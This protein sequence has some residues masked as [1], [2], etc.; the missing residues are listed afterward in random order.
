MKEHDDGSYEIFS[1][2]NFVAVISAIS[3]LWASYYVFANIDLI[4]MIGIGFYGWLN[5]QS[6]FLAGAIGV[7]ILG[8][9]TF[10]IRGVPQKI[11]QFAIK[12]FT[13]ELTLNNV[14]DVYDHFLRWYHSTG[15][16][17]R[18][19]T[20]VAKNKNYKWVDVA[21]GEFHD[22]DISAGYGV[23][24]FIY[25]GKVFQLTR[26][27]KDA[28][29]TKDIKESMT[30][31][32]VGRSQDQFHALLAAITPSNAYEESTK[33]HKW[34]GD[35]WNKRGSQA[36]RKFDSVILPKATKNNIVDH[37]GTF[38][39]EREWYMKHG[40]PY[41]T[42]MILHGIPGTGK[43][44]LVRALCDKFE[45]PLYILSLNGITDTTLE[46][47]FDELPHDSLVLIEDIDTYTVT[48]D[49]GTDGGTGGSSVLEMLTLG[50]LLNAID[51]VIASDGRILIATTNHIEKLDD[52]L[53]R[54][55][56]FDLSVEIGHLTHECVMEFFSSFYPD[57]VVP[58]DSEFRGDIVPAELQALILGNMENPDAVLDYCK[59]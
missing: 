44:S 20:L 24:Y 25:G 27:E 38:L 28:A 57:F 2:Y 41:R 21:D 47:A 14:D 39:G 8:V 12:Q 58:A 10:L 18:A 59:A 54:K 17:A 56:R 53:V 31:T 29:Q 30:I 15:R 22:M 43:T 19:R 42:G 51:G 6:P 3:I 13:V 23:H 37:I 52:A 40:I 11:M 55:G 9:S 34:C 26:N 7:W 33:I 16:S 46:D 50:G 48:S 36:S 1:Y 35:Y 4:K 5:N 32:T 45:K 49:R